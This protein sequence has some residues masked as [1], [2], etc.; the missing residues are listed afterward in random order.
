[1]IGKKTLGL[2]VVLALLIAA[3]LPAAAAEKTFQ[4]NIP[5]CTA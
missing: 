1:M 4:L 2:I 3:A 5:G